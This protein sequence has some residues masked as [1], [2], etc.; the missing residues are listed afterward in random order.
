[1]VTVTTGSAGVTAGLGG[2]GGHGGDG[3]AQRRPHARHGGGGDKRSQ[4][5]V[6]AIGVLEGAAG[7]TMMGGGSAGFPTVTVI[8]RTAG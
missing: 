4:S 8:M 1:M 2:H 6:S 5:V 7:M 3:H